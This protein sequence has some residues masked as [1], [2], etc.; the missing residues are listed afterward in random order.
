MR[1]YKETIIW[2]HGSR[3]KVRYAPITKWITVYDMFGARRVYTRTEGSRYVLFG[4]RG[5]IGR[6][7]YRQLR[8]WANYFGLQYLRLA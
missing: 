6:L 5:Y 4:P 2:A 7:S 1:L 3:F 8:H